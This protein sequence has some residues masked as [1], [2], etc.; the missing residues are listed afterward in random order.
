MTSGNHRH[1]RR[2]EQP[3]RRLSEEQELLMKIK[4]MS[5]ESRNEL[6]FM[7]ITSS[8]NNHQPTISSDRRRRISGSRNNRRMGSSS[9]LENLGSSGSKMRPNR[10]L[11]NLKRWSALDRNGSS[12][13]SGSSF[14]NLS[15]S[16][17]GGSS[18]SSSFAKF[19]MPI[20][21]PPSSSRNATW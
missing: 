9:S 18:S 8:R 12:N 5:V 20:S 6:A 13:L 16:L 1:H 11:E 4:Q 14:E 21:E 19:D 7:G 15:N 10:S 3:K 17:R 2:G